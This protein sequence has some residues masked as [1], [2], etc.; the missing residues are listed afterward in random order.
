M[1]LQLN[2][3]AMCGK[4]AS[5]LF[6]AVTV[7]L[8]FALVGPD[9]LSTAAHAQSAEQQAQH[10]RDMNDIA[11][12]PP[13]GSNGN[14]AAKD[15]SGPSATLPSRPM[16]PGFI[17]AAY[18]I[19]TGSIW[20]STTHKTID[21]AKRRALGGC[22]A[23]T[24]GGCYIVS[25]LGG[26]GKKTASQLFVS[27]DGMGQFWIKGASGN[28]MLVDPD[29]AMRDCLTQSFG[30]DSLSSYDMG[31]I[32][33]DLDPN[34]DQSEDF[35]PKGKLHW[36]RW[37][38]VARPTNPTTAT[39]NKSWLISGKQNSTETRKEILDRC[40]TDSGVPCS[41]SAYAINGKKITETDW[42]DTNGV[43][44]HYVDARGTNRWTNALSAP[45]KRKKKKSPL[46]GYIP[47]YPDPVTVTD[48]IDRL[49]PKKLPCRVVATYD[50]ATPRM[51]IIEDV[52]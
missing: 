48:R 21:S 15:L 49:C 34:L 2:G 20:I 50:A 40:Q 8:S 35:F 27:Q 51:Q 26:G 28:D 38:M 10:S 3:F 46:G 24:G 17:A 7:T 39:H 23:A 42:V 5:A 4:P 19:D 41:I 36:N 44:V 30:C 9:M 52:K 1:T 11:A 45:L 47:T 37:A 13:Q 22:N 12:T 29:P 33:T 31:N 16:R 32:Y 25:A 14:P 43:L 6:A 18:H